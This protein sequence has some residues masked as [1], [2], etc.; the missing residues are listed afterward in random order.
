M[1]SSALGWTSRWRHGRAGVPSGRPTRV[2]RRWS[3]SHAGRTVGRSA[4]S[5]LW[6]TVKIH[7]RLQ[8][9]EAYHYSYALSKPCRSGRAL[10]SRSDQAAAALWRGHSRMTLSPPAHQRPPHRTS[11]VAGHIAQKPYGPTRLRIVRPPQRGERAGHKEGQQNSEYLCELPCLNQV[12]AA[13]PLG[14]RRDRLQAEPDDQERDDE[15]ERRQRP[16]E[17]RRHRCDLA[18]V[19]RRLFYDVG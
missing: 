18:R 4:A 12:A 16:V 8:T 2:P 14:T 7:R 1:R 19:R 11:A 6:Y 13:T 5:G 17:G 9:T 3:Y 15:A 10:S